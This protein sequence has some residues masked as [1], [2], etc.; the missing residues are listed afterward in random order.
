MMFQRINRTDPEKGFIVVKNSYSTAALS[1][2]QAIIWDYPTDADGVGVTRPT[3]RATNAG[4]AIAGVAVEAIAAGSYGKIQVYGYNSSTRVRAATS[5]APTVIAG[6]PLVLNAAGSLFCLEGMSTGSD[7]IIT[8]PCGF[9][10][11]SNLL[12]TTSAIAVFLKCL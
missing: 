8:Y 7:A 5:A 1:S 10:L 4:V 11:A 12:W 2:G 3:A 9:A 6:R